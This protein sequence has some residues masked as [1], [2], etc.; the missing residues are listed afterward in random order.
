MIV[1]KLG[2]DVPNIAD[3]S[4]LTGERDG[5]ITQPLTQ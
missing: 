2:A 1:E 4:Q 3:N 5:A